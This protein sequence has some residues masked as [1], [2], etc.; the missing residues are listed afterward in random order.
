VSGDVSVYRIPRRQA[1]FAVGVVVAF[2]VSAS[3]IFEPDPSTGVLSKPSDYLW[4]L[5]PSALLAL[6]LTV[7]AHRTRVETNPAGITMFHVMNSEHVPWA[8][9]VGF[10]VHPT[11]SRRGSTVLARTTLGR[12]VR[13]RTFMGVRGGT[14]HRALATELRDQLEADRDRRIA[15]LGADP[16]ASLAG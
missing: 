6:Y 2:V 11:P 3:I 10:E 7:R 4:V 16:L 13:V 5:I 9:V 1:F 8:E 14:D 15:H 12:L